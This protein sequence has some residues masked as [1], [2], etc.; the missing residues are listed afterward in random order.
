MQRK[1]VKKTAGILNFILPI[2]GISVL[3]YCE[4]DL[5]YYGAV[6]FGLSEK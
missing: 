2:V 3:E 6:G 1:E 4:E 5:F